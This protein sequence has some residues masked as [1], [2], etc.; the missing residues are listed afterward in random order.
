MPNNQEEKQELLIQ[1]YYN[2]IKDIFEDYGNTG[3]AT[4]K[5]EAQN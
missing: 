2:Q 1:N 4:F 3:S 5:G